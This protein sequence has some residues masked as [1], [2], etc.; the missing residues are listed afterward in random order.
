ML[1]FEFKYKGIKP[2]KQHYKP[3]YKSNLPLLH[4]MHLNGV[5]HF[6][7]K[8]KTPVEKLYEFPAPKSKQTGVLKYD[9][10]FV[11]RPL[12]RL[13]YKH[14]DIVEVDEKEILNNFH[15][16]KATAKV[17]YAFIKPMS[18]EQT[19][20]N[21]LKE[22]LGIPN[23]LTALR[24]NATQNISLPEYEK[25]TAEIEKDYMDEADDIMKDYH[26]KRDRIIKNQFITDDGKRQN[27]LNKIEGEKQ[28]ALDYL[29]ERKNEALNNLQ[30][31]PA[32]ALLSS[33]D[34]DNNHQ[35]SI[36]KPVSKKERRQMKLEKAKMDEMKIFAEKMKELQENKKSSV[37][38]DEK[39]EE[40]N[41]TD[42]KATKDE[43]FHSEMLK[44]N[45]KMSLCNIFRN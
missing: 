10:D 38:N 17:D 1:N 35:S 44:L 16:D 11:G 34:D 19:Q 24:V 6:P 12:P 18:F 45:K 23:D 20:L 9:L 31:T 7:K 3:T 21:N 25:I 30:I 36:P 4:E 33:N 37:L 5:K 42:D 40:F 43:N 13:R 8:P 26:A 22:E 2:Y 29:K 27:R 15:Q 28:N 39:P 41:L 14:E 32:S